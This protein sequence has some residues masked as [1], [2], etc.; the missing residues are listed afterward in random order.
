MEGSAVS[1]AD[2]RHAWLLVPL[3]SSGIAAHKELG[4]QTAYNADERYTLTAVSCW[5]CHACH[6]RPSTKRCTNFTT[7]Q[8]P[9]LSD[10]CVPMFAVHG[11]TQRCGRRRHGQY[12]IAA[13]EQTTMLRDGTDAS[14][15]EPTGQI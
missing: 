13:S 12:S 6:G 14:T 2:G 1:P 4:L 3:V 10:T 7:R 8:L 5:R 15:H 11:L 9:T